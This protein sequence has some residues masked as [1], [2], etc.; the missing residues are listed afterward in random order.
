MRAGCL[1]SLLIGSAF[2]HGVLNE[3]GS[4]H[5]GQLNS[6]QRVGLKC[7]RGSV[8]NTSDPGLI[9]PK[10]LGR[11]G[12]VLVSF[13]LPLLHLLGF[14]ESLAEIP[15]SHWNSYNFPAC[16]SNA[17]PLTLSWT[18]TYSFTPGQA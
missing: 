15:S 12:E 13:D 14:F 10:D 17:L 11:P 2:L 9:A 3:V 16:C 4:V 8:R 1:S 5:A 7:L 6:V 18:V